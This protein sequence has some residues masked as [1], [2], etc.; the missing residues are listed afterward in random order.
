MISLKIALLAGAS[1]AALLMPTVVSADATAP[2][3]VG[4]A[5]E[6]T[7]CGVDAVAAGKGLRPPLG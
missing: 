1:A 7:E 4:A 2:C 6:T 3:N 5:A